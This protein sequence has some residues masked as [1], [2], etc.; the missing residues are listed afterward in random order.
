VWHSIRI[1][2]RVVSAV[3]VG[4]RRIAVPK[5]ACLPLWACNESLVFAGRLYTNFE[6]PRSRQC[7]QVVADA[8]ILAIL[9]GQRTIS[10]KRMEQPHGQGRGDF[11]ELLEKHHADVKARATT[12]PRFCCRDCCLRSDW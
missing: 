1:N 8:L 5:R 4:E 11:L 10:A 6:T 2:H 7:I 3:L 12:P 9:F